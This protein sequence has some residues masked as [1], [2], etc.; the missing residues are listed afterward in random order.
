MVINIGLPSLVQG[1]PSLDEMLF[2]GIQGNWVIAGSPGV[3]KT[4]LAIS[5]L[6]QGQRAAGIIDF[7][8]RQGQEKHALLYGMG[9]K[10]IHQM[11][12]ND[13]DK[14]PKN[15]K[16]LMDDSK[17][18]RSNA[19]Y[20]ADVKWH[21][22]LYYL[23][24]IYDRATFTM[25]G[26]KPIIAAEQTTVSIGLDLGRNIAKLSLK[27]G[28]IN[29]KVVFDY[30]GRLDQELVNDTS[31]PI[32]ALSALF[33]A[34]SCVSQGD[35]YLIDSVCFD[36]KAILYQDRETLRDLWAMVNGEVKLPIPFTGTNAEQLAIY[37]ERNSYT[38][39]RNSCLTSVTI[40]QQGAADIRQAITA[41][42]SLPLAPEADGI[43]VL[44]RNTNSH[45]TFSDSTP[46]PQ[47]TRILAIAKCRSGADETW[48]EYILGQ[49]GKPALGR[50]IK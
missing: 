25:F 31:L 49:D 20:E 9:V 13:R 34:V 6:A 37:G 45:Y 40:T 35:R 18:S 47:K 5:F 2:E 10:N 28:D 29:E 15:I 3:G 1:L 8:T 11:L 26:E 36:K 21:Y 39:P 43:I 27:P 38:L 46:V 50:E 33:Y 19:R 23:K 42:E 4:T 17:P 12:E 44:G 24:H 30:F 7:G 32:T 22:A 14:Q 16:W 48:R 41:A